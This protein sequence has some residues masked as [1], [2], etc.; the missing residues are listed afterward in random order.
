M[1][2]KVSINF[3]LLIS[4][5]FLMIITLAA[6]A[7]SFYYKARKIVLESS[8][9][10]TRQLTDKIINRTTAYLNAPA[11]Q[12]K[13]ISQ[14]VNSPNIMSN[15]EQLWR[16]M[17]EQMS[18]LPQVQSIFVADT[19]GNYV[20]VRRDPRLATRYIDRT[21]DTPI[22]KWI[23]RDKNY[24]IL[25]QKT[26]IPFFDPRSRPWYKNTKTEKKVYW[27][28]VYLFSTAQTPGIS[29]TFPVLDQAG[30]KM[31]VVAV[32]S[33]LHS[34]SDFLS[35]QDF[36]E[37]GLVFI[38]NSNHE[39]I[40]FPDESLL[41][42]L[43]PNSGLRRMA[44]IYDLPQKWIRDAYDYYRLTSEK[45]FI[46]TSN[47]Q[48]YITN[49]VPFPKS[50]PS[51]WHVFVVIPETDV[52]GLLNSVLTQTLAIFLGVFLFSIILVMFFSRQVSKPIRQLALQTEKIKHLD[53]AHITQV[54][55]SIIEIDLM[56]KALSS[57]KTGLQAFSRY[58]PVDLLRQLNE[59]EEEQQRAKEV[60]I[61]LFF[62]NISAFNSLLKR[63]EPE[64]LLAQ[65][66]AYLD[67]MAQLIKLEQGIIDKYYSD[68][69]L[70]F[71]G[72]PIA[73]DNS[74]Y[75]ACKAALLCQSK[76]QELNKLW[77]QQHK[78]H[79]QS[80]IGLHTGKTI[81]G[82]I[83]VKDHANYSIMGNSVNLALHLKALNMI[84]GT[85]IIISD[86]THARV[87][88]DFFCRLLDKIELKGKIKSMAIYELIC[89]QKDV[90]EKLPK[91]MEYYEAY[92]Q[93]FSA[94]SDQ[95]WQEALDI[96][97][98]LLKYD[99]KDKS[100]HLLIKRCEYFHNH[101]DG[102]A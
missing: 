69:I 22:E 25:E 40:A 92:K 55:S 54:H 98:S 82:S 26:E 66:S 89:E 32:N 19:L 63:T 30:N 86:S 18:V 60:E 11:L 56:N 5:S 95:Q 75:A 45:N 93:A 27:T 24:Q 50:F 67:E 88:N 20:Q 4:F 1:K 58:V 10:V 65:L 6:V 23:Y 87:S 71:W 62:S 29:A 79:L 34:L 2:K 74:P 83:N 8:N 76:N 70:A 61:T 44:L 51:E 35:E 33:P 84:Y 53:L 49:V 102:L 81:V 101:P 64:L 43:L 100:V 90:P 9:N 14:L 12:S 59:L 41:T 73:I 15:H 46:F 36:S 28:D 39:L 47:K 48:K 91:P 77:Q 99:E 68:T 38:T 80:R 72:A 94:Y 57:A 97:N 42:T 13:V 21:V 16:F 85:R 96:L 3:I 52:Y 78:P 7:G 17:W 37:N 31:A